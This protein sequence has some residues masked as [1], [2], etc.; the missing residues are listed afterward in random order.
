LLLIRE[1]TDECYALR[2]S[3]MDI[4]EAARQPIGVGEIC[5]ALRRIYAVDAETCET[6]VLRQVEELLAQG[7]FVRTL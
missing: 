2:G 4:W 1:E 5:D 3:A 7:L 6:N